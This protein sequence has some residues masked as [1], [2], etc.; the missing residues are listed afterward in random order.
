MDECG[1]I[2]NVVFVVFVVFVLGDYLGFI[3]G[4]V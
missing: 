2:I 1:K 4:V 3:V